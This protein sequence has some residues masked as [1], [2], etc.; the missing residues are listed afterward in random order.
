MHLLSLQLVGSK[1][2][3][4]V[5]WAQMCSLLGF[6]GPHFGKIWSVGAV[7]GHWCEADPPGP[8]DSEESSSEWC[9]IRAWS[10]LWI[11]CGQSLVDT[12][13]VTVTSLMRSFP[14]T[15]SVPGKKLPLRPTLVPVVPPLPHI[16]LEISLWE[17]LGARCLD[18]PRWAPALAFEESVTLLKLIN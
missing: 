1:L 6:A 4:G 17:L 8:F 5:L 7:C 10:F 18:F 15:A 3:G 12:C 11:E 16:L 9:C 14:L 2:I 13:P